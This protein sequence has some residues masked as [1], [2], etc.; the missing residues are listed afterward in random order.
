MEFE[1][2][3]AVRGRVR[4]ESESELEIGKDSTGCWKRAE[5]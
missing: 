4:P 5:S 3:M 2:V 1:R